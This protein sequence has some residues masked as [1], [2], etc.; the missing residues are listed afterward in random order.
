[1]YA[2]MVVHA[3]SEGLLDLG[4]SG[5]ADEI[6]ILTKIGRC[7]VLRYADGQSVDWCRTHIENAEHC[8]RFMLR[9]TISLAVT[10]TC[11]CVNDLHVTYWAKDG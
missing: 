1:M 8:T 6:H 11:V 3:T 9:A 5:G 2:Q 4:L 7:Q 10:A